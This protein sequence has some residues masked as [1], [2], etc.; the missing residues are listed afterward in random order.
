MRGL[1]L[2][3]RSEPGEPSDDI[4]VVLVSPPHTSKGKPKVAVCSCCVV[5]LVVKART[6]FA[7]PQQAF[8]RSR[9]Q[10][11]KRS[12]VTGYCVGQRHE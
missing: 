1:E 5:H 11:R 7:V 10:V 12:F 8:D 9:S 3:R 2:E 6:V 4:W